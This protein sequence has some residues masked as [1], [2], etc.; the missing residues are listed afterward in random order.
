MR[1]IQEPNVD[2]FFT[3]VVKIV[4]DGVIG[5]DGTYKK[6]DTIVCA[7]GFDTS[8]R[9]A[10][11]I[12]GENGVDLA[13]KWKHKPEGYLGVGVP[14]FPNLVCAYCPSVTSLQAPLLTST[15]FFG[16]TWPV[17]GGSVVGSLNAVCHYAMSLM[18]KMQE[19]MIKSMSPRQDVTDSF[20]DHT[21]TLLRGMVW[22]D[23]CRSWCKLSF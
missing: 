4:E 18:E 9:P 14:G 13:D 8:Y 15:A 17:A 19:D 10:Y 7:T 3:P 22:E 20:N 11:R 2:V 5:E 12:V 23:D 21:Q 1:A 16:P 6:A